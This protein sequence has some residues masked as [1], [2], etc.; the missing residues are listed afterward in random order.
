MSSIVVNKV[1]YELTNEPK[2]GVVR[3]I[4]KERQNSIKEFLSL[5]TDGFDIEPSK[6]ETEEQKKLDMSA[7]LDKEISR[8][9][10]EHPNEAVEFGESEAE[11]NIRA[12][13]SLTANHYFVEE[14]FD[15]M[16]EKEITETFEKCK[17]VLGGDVNH[18][19][20]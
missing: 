10:K 14:D 11:F 8:L 3:R 6:A 12:T 2:H 18:F 19:F 16:T 7:N 17:E 5:F 20:E 9:L 13:I 4:R 1:A 15:E